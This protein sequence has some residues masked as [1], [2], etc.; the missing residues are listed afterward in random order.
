MTLS[1]NGGDAA[2]GETLAVTG[3]V[4]GTQTVDAVVTNG[5]GLERDVQMDIHR[6]TRH[7]TA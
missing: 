2:E 5:A 3:L 7:H 4:S 1:L 6:R